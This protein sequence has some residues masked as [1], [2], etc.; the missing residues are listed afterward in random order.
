VSVTI[1]NQVFSNPLAL[2]GRIQE[3]TSDVLQT[4]GMVDQIEV[5]A[6]GYLALDNTPTDENRK[7]NQVTFIE[8]DLFVHAKA[9]KY[10]VV[11][12]FEMIDQRGEQTTEFK[13]SMIDGRACYEITVGGQTATISEDA[14]GTLFFDLGK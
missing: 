12:E 8:D 5:W 9:N 10:G 3:I 1:G 6:D 13:K 4:Q 14:N 2:R 7:K 11:Q